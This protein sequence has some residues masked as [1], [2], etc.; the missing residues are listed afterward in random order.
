MHLHLQYPFQYPF[1]WSPWQLLKLW[2]ASF[3]M[4]LNFT[5]NF[6]VIV[7]VVIVI[8]NIFILWLNIFCLKETKS[9][10]C[11]VPN[12]ILLPKYHFDT[13]SIK[14]NDYFCQQIL[15]SNN[16]RIC[17]E[18]TASFILFCESDWH[19]GTKSD[20]FSSVFLPI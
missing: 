10:Y 12:Y 6:G 20:Q 11:D 16:I 14:D 19:I 2:S 4:H 18:K 9:I 13:T 5:F 3:K 17:F 1:H 15:K 8:A 7:F